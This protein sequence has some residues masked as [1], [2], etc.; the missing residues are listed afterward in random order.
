MPRLSSIEISPQVFTPPAHFHAVSG[1]VSYPYSPGYG[2]VWNVHTRAPVTTSKAR[3]SP[4]V[5]PYAS[6]VCDPVMNRFSK[7][8]PGVALGPP[9]GRTGPARMSTRPLVPNVVI[10]S[11]VR[12]SISRSVPPAPKMSRRSIRSLLCQYVMPRL[13][14]VPSST[15]CAQSRLPVTA[16]AATMAFEGPSRYITPSTTI[17]L[18]PKF[19]SLCNPSGACGR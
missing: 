7:T 17:G 4:G 11:P 1:H 6:P 13:P 18:K 8:R 14:G 9:S 16:S 5:E 3:R 2:M 10:G 15:T 19:P 12:A